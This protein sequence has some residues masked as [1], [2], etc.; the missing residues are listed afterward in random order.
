MH[1]LE[2]HDSLGNLLPEVTEV[3]T[4]GYIWRS[5]VDSTREFKVTTGQ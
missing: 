1:D 5:I 2:D 3:H 4:S